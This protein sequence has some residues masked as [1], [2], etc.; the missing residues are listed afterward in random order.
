MSGN[1]HDEDGDAKPDEP[2]ASAEAG[3]EAAPQD[4]REALRRELA[5]VKEQLLRRRADFENYK[6][7]MERDR[8]NSG[9]AM[10]E[11]IFTELIPALDNLER[12]LTASGDDSSLRAGVELIHR[13]L[14]AVFE[15]HGVKAHD[16]TGQ[17]FDPMAHQALSHEVVP[18]LE[19]GTVAEA[20]RKGYSYRDRLLRPALV[21]VA[22]GEEGQEEEA[23]EAPA[24][25]H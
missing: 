24:T 22:K 9:H 3:L 10:A 12:A 16:P 1:G 25:E 20:F 4:E 19:E 15:R 21:K 2:V 17:L 23:A 11:K 6:K 18:G 7:R 8:E 5:E 14:V 13:E